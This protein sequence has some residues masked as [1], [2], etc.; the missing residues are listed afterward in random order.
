M[1]KHKARRIR[2]I[3]QLIYNIINLNRIGFNSKEIS[4]ILQ[5]KQDLEEQQSRHPIKKT[6]NPQLNDK[7]TNNKLYGA[8]QPKHYNYLF[9]RTTPA[10]RRDNKTV[11]FNFNKIN[12]L[13]T[14]DRVPRGVRFCVLFLKKLKLGILGMVFL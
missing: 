11:A 3:K 7:Y 8:G 5:S 6:D 14:L 10:N 9:R 2:E 4:R 12:F 13:S 1:K